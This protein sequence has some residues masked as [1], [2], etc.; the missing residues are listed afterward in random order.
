M[1]PPLHR[2]DLENA[3]AGKRNNE[4]QRIETFSDGVFAFAVT[5]LIV[6]LE[7]PHSFN[8]LI[9]TMR[10]FLGFGISFFILVFIW[11]E[12]HRFFR[13][14][15][16]TDGGTL[17][18]NIALLFLVL[19]YVYPLKFLFSLLFGN[20]VYGPEKSPFTIDYK[21][22]PLLMSIYALGFIAIYFLFFLMYYRAR[23]YSE[24]LGMSSLER[25][26][27]GSTMYRMLIM[28]T[29]GGFSLLA[30][31]LLKDGQA[32]WAGYVYFLLWPAITIFYRYRKR[33]RKKLFH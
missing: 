12:Q 2:Q 32:G 17:S 23:C 24:K 20:M 10:G 14:Y 18:L 6:S 16:M 33:L 8:E 25:F 7:V 15:G 5:L 21:Q 29:M 28:V 19:F 13:S 3:R 1:N 22:I 31:L 4:I 26:D 11:L 27:C 30:S 9:I